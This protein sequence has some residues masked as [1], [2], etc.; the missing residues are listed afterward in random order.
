MI[1]TVVSYAFTNVTSDHTISASF[2]LDQFTI[3]A[4]AGLGGTIT[5][6][7]VVPVGY[8]GSQS[9]AIAA[10]LGYHI[11]DVLV[12]SVSVGP[13]ASYAFT[14]VTSDHTISASF[15]LDQFTITATAGLGGTI[16]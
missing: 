15:A 10:N 12:D 5:P 1:R 8:G 13:V 4:T 7:G 11:S 6:S 3:T 14:N 16:T 2:A 9:F